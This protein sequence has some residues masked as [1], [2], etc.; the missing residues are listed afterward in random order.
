MD[1][2]QIFHKVFF[3]SAR[4]NVRTYYY[5]MNFKTCSFFRKNRSKNFG[6]IL[7]FGL[8]YDA[9]LFWCGSFIDVWREN[10]SY[11][12][13]LKNP[14]PLILFSLMTSAGFGF[15]SWQILK[16]EGEKKELLYLAEV[17]AWGISVSALIPY[18]NPDGSLQAA[19][20]NDLHVWISVIC[21]GGFSALWI[22]F[23]RPECFCSRRLKSLA[24]WILWITAISVC[25]ISMSTHVCGLSE[26][27]Y[28]GA[29]MAL[30]LISF[31]FKKPG[32]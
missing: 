12:Y 8:M 26:L 23:L 20:F 15:F 24:Q 1:P 14:F 32:R 3:L 16:E 7:L 18:Q 25:M 27:F 22:Q 30:F 19:V 2:D 10:I 29:M 13:I 21:V 4:I 9:V 17:L 11:L 28:A 6:L 5:A 31:L